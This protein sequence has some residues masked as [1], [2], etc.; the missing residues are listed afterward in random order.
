MPPAA[1][2]DG[3]AELVEGAQVP[4]DGALVDVEALREFGTG[5]SGSCLE[6]L[7]EGQYAARG[8]GHAEIL[9]QSGPDRP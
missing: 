6:E 5:E 3:D 2:D 4:A 9:Q 7:E 1:G 8:S